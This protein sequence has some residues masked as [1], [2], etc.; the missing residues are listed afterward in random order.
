[1]VDDSIPSSLVSSPLDVD[2][3]SVE[4][5][6]PYEMPL[7]LLSALLLATLGLLLMLRRLMVSPC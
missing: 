1:M 2:K 6:W 4:C 7:W 5:H 3:D